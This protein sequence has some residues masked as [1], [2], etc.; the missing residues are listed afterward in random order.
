MKK[1]FQHTIE[2]TI[3]C[4]G[5]GVHSGAVVN[6]KFIPAAAGH[7]IIFKRV[8]LTD[9]PNEIKA[10]FKNVATTNLG[11]TLK[12]ESGADIATVEHLMS[13]LW[14]MRIDNL[15]IEVDNV[16]IPVFDGSSEPFMFVLKSAGLKKQDEQRKFIKINQKVTV[17]SSAQD[18]KD[19]SCSLEPDNNFVVDFA[20]E[21]ANPVIGKQEHSYQSNQDVFESAIAR[22]RTFGQTAE[23][24]YLRAQGL[25]LGGSL[26][27]AIVVAPDKVMNEEG[28]RYQNEFV[29]HKILDAVGDLYLAGMPIIGKYV[30]DKSGHDLNNKLLHELFSDEQNYQII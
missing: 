20:I 10:D 18:G 21:F 30:G 7:G 14:G 13:A 3:A 4:S 15:L 8:D 22:A 25:A 23:I 29:R 6:L 11:T 16:E 19:L 26:E 5:I 17:S 24:E 1:S 27:N 9:Q 28:I 2:N 12:N